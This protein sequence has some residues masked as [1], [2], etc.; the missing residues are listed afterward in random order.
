MILGTNDTGYKRNDTVDTLTIAAG[1]KAIWDPTALP[2]ISKSSYR[3]RYH[4]PRAEFAEHSFWR[5]LEAMNC[6]NDRE[7]DF[8]DGTSEP[9]K[10]GFLLLL[11]AGDND[12]LAL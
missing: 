9:S 1:S 8:G 6:N 3:R 10:T 2:Q 4:H 7:Q 5:F 11:K 12:R